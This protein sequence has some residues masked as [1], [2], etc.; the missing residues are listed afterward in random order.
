MFSF[1][2]KASHDAA[3]TVNPL[4]KHGIP[5]QTS[6]Q[7]YVWKEGSLVKTWKQRYLVLEGEQKHLAYYESK[8]SYQA[9]TKAKGELNYSSVEKK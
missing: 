2:S 6:C 3:S 1:F 4:K 5:K 7:G 9:E 8:Q